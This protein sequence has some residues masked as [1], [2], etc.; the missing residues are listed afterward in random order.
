MVVRSY[1]STLTYCKKTYTQQQGPQSC[2][3]VVSASYFL[4]LKP[5]TLQSS[6]CW[7]KC[8]HLDL[9]QQVWAAGSD[10]GG[11]WSVRSPTDGL[12]FASPI[13]AAPWVTTTFG[14]HKQ[15]FPGRNAGRRGRAP[16]GRRAAKAA[17]CACERGKRCTRVHRR[18]LGYK[19]GQ[20]GPLAQHAR[21]ARRAGESN[22]TR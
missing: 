14:I 1:S 3:P 9:L 19:T 18:A 13:T 2:C 16:A 10:G 11:R 15:S 20:S 4:R 6:F 21:W 17:C 8:Y 22:G 12:L 5:R 7:D